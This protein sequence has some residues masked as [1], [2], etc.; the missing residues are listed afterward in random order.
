M[1]A[2]A[3]SPVTL[4]ILDAAN[5]VVRRWSSADKVAVVNPD[6]LNIPAFWRPAPPVLSAAAGMHRWVWDLRGM[7]ATGGGAGAGAGVG[8]GGA[9]VVLPGQYTVRLTAAGKTLTQPLEVQRDPRT[10]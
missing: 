5:T 9:S 1:Q 2:T 8:R 4:E 3:T 10:R 7:P 6:T